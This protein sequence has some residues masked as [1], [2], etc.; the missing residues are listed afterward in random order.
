MSQ[1]ILIAVVLG[2]AAVLALLV[3]QKSIQEPKPLAIELSLSTEPTEPRVSAPAPIAQSASISKSA[4]PKPSF[5]P[6]PSPSTALTSEVAVPTQPLST[7]PTASAATAAE[8]VKAVA[9]QDSVAL[10][11]KVPMTVLLNSDAAYLSNPKPSYPPLS[12]RLGEQGVVMLSVFV[13]TSGEVQKL[14]LA[15]S[16]GFLRLDDAAQK[17]VSTWRFAPGKQAG[18]LQAMWVKVP[19]SFI[20]EK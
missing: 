7:M 14:E 11:T 3:M 4:Q 18:V 6:S 8:A 15:K 5:T 17:T 2:H 12:R 1:R 20:L 10:P 19:I 13:G 16:S 9:A